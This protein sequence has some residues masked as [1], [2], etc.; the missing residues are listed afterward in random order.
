MMYLAIVKSSTFLIPLISTIV[1]SSRHRTNRKF[2]NKVF[3][4]FLI[5]LIVVPLIYFFLDHSSLIAE[6]KSEPFLFILKI[7]GIAL[8]ISLVIS[9]WGQR[10]PE[11]RKW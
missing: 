11:L 4:Y 7:A 10:D 5:Y 1:M 9:F 3:R 2:W 6:I 8:G